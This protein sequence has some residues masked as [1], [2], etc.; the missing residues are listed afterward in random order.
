MQPANDLVPL[1]LFVVRVVRLVVE[2]DHRPAAI[3]DA[4]VEVFDSRGLRGR[5][6]PEHGRQFLRLVI[7]RSFCRS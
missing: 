1:A 7:A 5:L 6:W 3:D 2:H 4:L